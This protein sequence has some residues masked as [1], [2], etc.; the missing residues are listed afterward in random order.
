LEPTLIRRKDKGGTTN[1]GGTR[2]HDPGLPGTEC[3]E[4]SCSGIHHSVY[5]IPL[6]SFAF[7]ISWGKEPRQSQL[8]ICLKDVSTQVMSSSWRCVGICGN[9][10]PTSM[11]RNYSPSKDWRSMSVVSGRGYKPMS[12]KSTSVVA[13]I[14][15]PPTRAIGSARLIARDKKSIS[16]ERSIPPAR[17]STFCSPPNVTKQPQARK[18]L[19]LCIRA[20]AP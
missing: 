13:P 15:S 17:P 1:T 10:W 20:A 16:I 14:G 19:R 5:K 7:T 9:D 11:S 3:S 18:S 8:R 2:S 12:R 6:R 4:H